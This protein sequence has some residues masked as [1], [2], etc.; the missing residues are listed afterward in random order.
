M[1]RQEWSVIRRHVPNYFACPYV[2]AGIMLGSVTGVV[3]LEILLK[4]C[5]R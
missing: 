2:W 3:L 5:Q 4:L 1:S